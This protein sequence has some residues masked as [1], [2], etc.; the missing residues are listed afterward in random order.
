MRQPSSFVLILANLVPLGG[1]LLFQWDVLSILLLYWTESVIV[2]VVNVL[3]MIASQPD[4][5]TDGR[6]KFFL[7]PFF[8][9]HYGLFCY[10][11]LTAV[12]GFFSDRNLGPTS[13]LAELWQP[14]FWIV[15]A[16]IAGSHLFSFFRN[17]LGSD[18]RK[19]ATPSM[20][21]HRPYGR[22]V[23]M[24]IAIVV[25]AGLVNWFG[26]TVPLLLVLIG[27]KI[28]MDLKLHEMERR[29]LALLRNSN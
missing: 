28:V 27:A 23:A 29:K 24:H 10:G 11:H 17:F 5:V 18:E 16:A 4:K 2:G 1:V 14:S 21:M 8:T 26:S 19:R 22:I 3:R 15:V 9:I 7:I 20:L 6:S 12:I 13:S 25:G